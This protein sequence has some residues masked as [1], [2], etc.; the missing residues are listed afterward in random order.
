MDKSHTAF[1]GSIPKYYDEYLGPLIFEDYAIDLVKRLALPTS[2]KV[3]ETAAGTGIVTYHLRNTLPTE[4][5]IIATDLNE[6]MLEHAKLKLKEHNNLRFQAA[7]ATQLPFPD[8]SF[9]A[10]ICQFSL[11]FF[12]DKQA[13]FTEVMRVLK[14]RGECVFNIWDSFEHNHLVR[15]VDESLKRL[16]PNDPLPFYEIPYGYFKIDE[17]KQLLMQAGFEEIEISVLPKQS[18]SKT[19]RH[20]ALAYIQGT[21]A[22]LQITKRGGLV[23]DIVEIVANDIAEEFGALDIKAKMQAVVFEVSHP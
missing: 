19:A 9:D 8:N 17:V 16:F 14:P 10:V 21:P 6:A 7:N 23:E 15:A 4:V 11:M 12:P 1:V 5:E 13:A 22:C 18:Y 20:V 3:L 2:G